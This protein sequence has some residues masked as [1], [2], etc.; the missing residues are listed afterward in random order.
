M[1]KKLYILIAVIFIF[2]GCSKK[3]EEINKNLIPIE[4]NL[5]YGN[6]VNR[7]LHLKTHH[8]KLVIDYKNQTNIDYNDPN[9]INKYS[10]IIETVTGNKITVGLLKGE[11]N[12]RI[13][14]FEFNIDNLLSWGNETISTNIDTAA[15]G[16]ISVPIII[17]NKQT[18]PN[19]QNLDKTPVFF[20]LASDSNEINFVSFSITG[21]APELTFKCGNEV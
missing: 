16:P 3:T 2:F 9:S 17:H 10:P 12:I 20:A 18:D 4:I 19:K 13:R 15:E 7:S 21:K 14:I 11:Q 8:I 6:L 5:K 1:L